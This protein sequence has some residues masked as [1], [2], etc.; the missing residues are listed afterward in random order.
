MQYSP[1]QKLLLYDLDVKE[2][3]RWKFRNVYCAGT[4][5]LLISVGGL[6]NTLKQDKVPYFQIV[7]YCMCIFLSL[8]N[9]VIPSLLIRYGEL[10]TSCLNFV[11]LTERDI[12]AF[13]TGPTEK[14]DRI[15]KRNIMI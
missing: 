14:L 12:Q 9:M 8:L 3:K 4:I 13:A 7:L 6:S 10:A 15:S 2:F 1:N 11:L 5:L